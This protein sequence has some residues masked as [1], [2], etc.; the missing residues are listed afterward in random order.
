MAF[1][2]KNVVP[3]GRNLSEYMNMFN[4]S[5]SDLNKKI[6]SFG[7]GP[8][9]FNFE[10]DSKGK[11]CISIDPIYQFN[12]QELKERFNEVRIEV[13]KQI[14]SNKDNFVWDVIKTPEDLESIRVKSISDFLTDFEKGKV[15][16][17]YVCHS[18]PEKLNFEDKAFELGFSSH[19][20]ILY[21]NLGLEF[22]IKAITEML[23]LCEEIRIFPILNLN[24]ENSIIL[25]D[26]IAFF[27]PKYGLIFE[28]VNYEF[29]QD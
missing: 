25:E 22:H 28:K 5:E 9:S 18:L 19:F 29:Y 17:R 20:L 10:M 7:D 23:R 13:M 16:N 3:W 11:K 8:A 4:L 1:E 21:S 24:A 12:S 6:I 2:L 14:N 27:E 15:E 26:I